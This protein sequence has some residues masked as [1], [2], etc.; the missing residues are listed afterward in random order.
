MKIKCCLL[1][2]IVLLTF[3]ACN[4]EIN[5]SDVGLSDNISEDYTSTN[6]SSDLTSDDAES[7]DGEISD[8]SKEV[9]GELRLTIVSEPK[10]L[11]FLAADENG[12]IYL[13]HHNKDVPILS[14]GVDVYVTFN[15]INEFNDDKTSYE[16]T[17]DYEITA[18]YVGLIARLY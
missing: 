18:T 10:E 15:H 3:T 13:V 4:T 2:F 16:A 11:S 14:K 6:E 8:I 12:T 17:P 9:N 7:N 5:K 1:L